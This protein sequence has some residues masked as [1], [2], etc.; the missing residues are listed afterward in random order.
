[1]N[2]LEQTPPPA[3]RPVDKGSLLIGF[4]LGW[5]VMAVSVVANVLFWSL[6]STLNMSDYAGVIFGCMPLIAMIALMVWFAFRNE[7]RSVSG[8]LLAFGSMIALIL[9]LVAACFGILASGG[10]GNMH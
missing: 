9:L 5:V 8:V 2:N 1:M 7:S 3:Q 6:Q 10:F 4:V